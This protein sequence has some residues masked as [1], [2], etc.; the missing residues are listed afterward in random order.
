MDIALSDGVVCPGALLSSISLL[1]RARVLQV[2]GENG[3]AGT[4]ES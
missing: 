4:G 2:A 3:E 1:P